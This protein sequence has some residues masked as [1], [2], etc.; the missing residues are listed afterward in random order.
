MKNGDVQALAVQNPLLMGHL[1]ELTMVKRLHCE[2]VESR[3]DTGVV[4]ATPENMEQPEIRDLLNPP[5]DQYLK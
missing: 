2:K 3:I 1:S 5:F 4:L